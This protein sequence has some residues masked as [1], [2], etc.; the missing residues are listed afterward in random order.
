MHFFEQLF[1]KS[2]W[3]IL[4]AIVS[5]TFFENNMRSRNQEYAKLQEQYVSLEKQKAQAI[6]LQKKLLL[7]INSQSDPDWVEMVL[8]KG[9]GVAP[10]GQIKVFFDPALAK[11][12]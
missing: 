9:L 12:P 3:V 10:E 8:M 11:K 4:I 6:E 7:D 1:F 2:W 5:F